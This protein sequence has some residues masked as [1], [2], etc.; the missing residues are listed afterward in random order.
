MNK[1]LMNK[2]II[3]K[4]T[5]VTKI[6]AN[7]IYVNK[8]VNV[9]FNIDKYSFDNIILD[10]EENSNVIINKKYNE[11]DINENI[12]INLNGIN[13]SIKY[14]FSTMV[15][16]NQ[17]Y[18][19]IINHNN[20]NTN[21][22]ITNHGVVLNDSKL[23]FEVN[24]IVKKGNILCNINQDSKIITMGR[25][26]SIIKPNLFID[27]YN[28]NAKHSAIIGKFNEEEIFYLK[29]KGLSEKQALDLLINGF[30]EGPM[31]R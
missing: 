15:T 18:T 8:N 6:N 30:I 3:N 12:V 17:K 11:K 5:I 1:I 27:E 10:I 4:D 19:I 24:S 21:S 31:R 14:N 2:V 22:Y 26:N 28:V 25:N 16:N 20:K 13:S 23:I 7:K 29:T 9:V